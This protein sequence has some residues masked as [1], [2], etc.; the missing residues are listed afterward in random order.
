MEKGTIIIAGLGPGGARQMSLETVDFMHKADKVILR[1]SVHP[2]VH[3]LDDENIKYTTCDFCYS[4]ETF[5]K[6]YE[7]I[8]DHCLENAKGTTLLYAVPGSPMVA[9]KSV[10]LLIEKAKKEGLTVKVLPA[11]S[12]L[13]VL[14]TELNIDPVDGLVVVDALKH[15]DLF[16]SEGLPLVITQV[17]DKNIASDLK[18][19]LME[20][21]SDEKKIIFLRNL[22]MEDKEVKEISLYELDRQKNIDHLTSIFIPAE[23]DIM[24]D[25]NPLV[26]T[27]ATLRSPNGCPWDNE[28]TSET[29]KRYLIEEVYE[30][31]EA[32]DDDDMDA[33]CDE[34][35]DL[36]LQIV[37][38]ARI[39]E[40]QSIFTIK[41]VVARIVDKMYRRHP[42]VFGTINVNSSDEVIN[43]WEEI[44]K[45]EYT[46]RKKILDGVPRGLPA[47]MVAEKMQKKAAKVGFD[48]DDIKDV[49]GKVDEEILELKEAIAKKDKQETENELGDILFALANL[50]RHLGVDPE[51]ALMGTNKRFK[52]RFTYIEDEIKKNS[53]KWEDFS[54]EELDVFWREA[55]KIY[56]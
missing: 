38:H 52:E 32:I 40:E 22:G 36:L 18:L 50:A 44:K 43:N 25:L 30:V 26:E 49:W 7:K 37:F 3:E 14:F 19:L 10:L 41:D 54:L 1:T 15:D 29:L 47:L 46:N 24:T 35:G 16:K 39:A 53:K 23:K 2:S 21:Y 42:H 5:D 55:K 17:Y 51:I 13:D 11:I 34:L 27:M 45:Q 9:E 33:L 6:V 12:F 48:W 56:I 20:K 31:I 28:Q 4:E 8:S